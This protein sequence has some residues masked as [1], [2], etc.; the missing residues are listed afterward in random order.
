MNLAVRDI[1]H[2]LARF[3][4]T[5]MGIGMI[6]MIVL[7]MS[8]IYRG[9]IEEATLLVDSTGADLWIVQHGTRGPFAEISKIPRNL[10]DRLLAV[11]GVLSARA[12]V[13]YSVQREYHGKPLRMTVQG[14]SWPEDKGEWLPLVAGRQLAAAHFEMIADE[15]L[16]LKLGDPLPLGKNIYTVVGITRGVASMAGDGLA[17]FTLLDALDIQYDTSGEAIRLERKARRA[18]VSKQDIGSTQPSFLE[19]AE[20]PGTRLAALPRPSVSAVTVRLRPGTNPA[21]VIAVIAGWG[22]VSVFTADQ[23][24]ALLLR[25]VVDR[26]R[27]QLGLF[28]VLLIIISAIIM[29]L[30]LYTLTLEK[31]HDIAMLKL[32]GARNSV[33]LSLV[34]QQGVL[35]GLIG[36]VVA[37]YA[38]Q[39]LFPRFPRRVLI[40]PED[41]FSLALIVLA[42]SIMA[43]CLGIWKA[44]KVDPNEVVS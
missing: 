13:T 42:V 20:L 28:R 31:L 22:D 5:A 23:Q 33:I 32:I 14:V 34:L 2:N 36:Y 15:I 21:S 26:A 37:V 16:G 44:L 24:R 12:F 7:G 17:F 8:G 25:G 3:L 10:E 27:R 30:I 39:W 18:R 6:L 38:G 41:L 4:L 11:P 29:A 35:L 43:S 40:T 19:R 9:L 1:R